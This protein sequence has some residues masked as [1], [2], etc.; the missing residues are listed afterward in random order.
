MA[1]TDNATEVDSPILRCCTEE[2]LKVADLPDLHGKITELGLEGEYAI[3]RDRYLGWRKGKSAGAAGELGNPL[4]G[5]NG[6]GY[7]Y[8]SMKQNWYWRNSISFWIATTFFEGSLFFT[9]SSFL[10]CYPEKL[11]KYE[12]AL[13]SY[14]YLAG[15]V[16]FFLCTYFMCLITANID[17]VGDEKA[18]TFHWCPFNVC[19]AVRKLRSVGCAPWPYYASLLYFLGVLIF[20]VGLAAEFIAFKQLNLAAFVIGSVFFVAGGVMECIENEVF[21]RFRCRFAALTAL[22][23][24][25]GS[26]FFLIGSALFYF[27]GYDYLGN[28]LFGVGS[29][30]FVVGSAGQI[31]MWRDGQFGLAF[32]S[33]LNHLKGASKAGRFSVRGAV[34]IMIYCIAATVSVYDFLVTIEGLGHHD[35]S[36]AFIFTIAFNA[37]LPCIFAHLALALNSAV[38]KP[39]PGAPFRQLYFAG[40]FLAL[41]MVA[42]ST[43]K[44]VQTVVHAAKG[45]YM[46]CGVKRPD[47]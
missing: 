10:A 29:V 1:D 32:F 8:Q 47:L 40:R 28:F 41:V 2:R 23:N 33:A 36:E 6:A 21:T 45:E 39:P 9:I 25:I 12:M 19:Q 31:L 20:G 27:P 3:F 5:E 42:S 22:V 46:A 37:L 43:Q 17:P 18:E 13:T 15:K 4:V 30:I 11:G 26:L 14:G 44:T 38:V 16:N 34:F 35:I 24:T 7:W